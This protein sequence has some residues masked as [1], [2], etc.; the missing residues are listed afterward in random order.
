MERA[1]TVL[2]IEGMS[3]WMD[4]WMD[5]EARDWVLLY[6][7]CRMRWYQHHHHRLYCPGGLQFMMR[8]ISCSGRRRGTMQDWDRQ[9]M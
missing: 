1:T 4:G 5:V 7:D 2:C 6:L 9:F 8:H 3:E